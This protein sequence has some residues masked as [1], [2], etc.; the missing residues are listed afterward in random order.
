MHAMSGPPSPR[1]PPPPPGLPIDD[2]I[3]FLGIAALTYGTHTI[4]N[5]TKKRKSLG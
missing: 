5:Y 1:R 4:Y 2:G 3:L